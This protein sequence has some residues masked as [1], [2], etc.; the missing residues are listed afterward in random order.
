MRVAAFLLAGL[1]T[2][3]I[4][5]SL[6][7]GDRTELRGA[8]ATAAQ[9]QPDV[10]GSDS[11][12]MWRRAQIRVVPLDLVAADRAELESLR[13][14]V[15]KAEADVARLGPVDAPAREQI[16][17]QAQLMRSL[18]NYADRHDSDQGK[19]PT[20]VEVERR[21]NRIEGEIMCEACHSGVVAELHPGRLQK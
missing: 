6:R 15:T 14:R 16:A 17:R 9:T 10:R 5:Q 4:S 3:T 18:L 19:G 11:T 20:A 13:A 2:L 1:L 7:G 21:L 8:P 12:R